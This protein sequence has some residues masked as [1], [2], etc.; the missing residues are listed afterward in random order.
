MATA[1]EVREGLDDYAARCNANPRLRTMHRAWSC[2]CLFSALDADIAFTVRI[3]EGEVTS[4]A[5]GEQPADLTISATSEDLADMFWGDLN[6]AQKYVNGEIKVIGSPE[7]M[8][9]VD[10]MA[11]VIWEEA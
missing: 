1:Q 11:A 8:L 10:A 5:E 7:D 4:V 2:T 6:P 9:R 3:D